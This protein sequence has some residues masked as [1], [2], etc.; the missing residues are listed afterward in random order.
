MLG[1]HQADCVLLSDVSNLIFDA[2]R[3]LYLVFMAIAC[4][5]LVKTLELIGYKDKS[6]LFIRGF[7]L[8]LL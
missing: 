1:M 8:E 6:K 2:H 7:Y 3:L 5:F 4:D